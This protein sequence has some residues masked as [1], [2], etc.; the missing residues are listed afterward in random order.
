[1]AVSVFLI[2]AVLPDLYTQ[3]QN[4]RRYI[5]IRMDALY[6][7]KGSKLFK[8]L[9]N[10]YVYT[11]YMKYLYICMYHNNVY[12]ITNVIRITNTCEMCNLQALVLDLELFVICGQLCLRKNIDDTYDMPTYLFYNRCRNLVTVRRQE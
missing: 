10:M 8:Y 9:N 11:L 3:N 1:M 6:I 12:F 7:V 4:R 5:N 2:N